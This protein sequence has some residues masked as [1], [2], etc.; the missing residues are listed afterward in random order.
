MRKAKRG[1][2]HLT[3]SFCKSRRASKN[4]SLVSG[5]FLGDSDQGVPS[6]LS[7]RLSYLTRSVASITLYNGDTIL[8]SCSGIV[9]ERQGRH[10]TRFL[11]SASLVRALNATNKDHDDL[12]IQVRLEGKEV[13]MG[14]MAEF[15]LDRNFAVVD[16][17][18]FLD[19]Q[20][21]SFQHAQI[22][23]HGETLVVI[24]RRVSGEI[25]TKNVELDG[26]SRVSEDDED[27]D[28]KISEAWEGGPLLSVDG[29]VVGMNLFLTTRRA[30][31]LP[32]GTILKHLEYY[33]TSQQKKTG[34]A[35]PKTSK[36]S[37]FGARPIGEKSNSHPEVHGDI[38]N[39]EQLD[40]DSMGYPKLPSSMLGAGMILVN[41]FEETF[42]DIHGEGVWRNFGE[43]AS[44][45]NRNVV[46]LASFNGKRRVFACTGFFIEWNGSTMIL[47]SASLVRNSGD[48]NK[49]V[50]N[51]RIE[52]LLNSQFREGTLQHYSL[53]YN[54]AL[55]S[56]KDYRA[57]RPSNTLLHWKKDFEVAAVGRCFE[58]GA[59]MATT[60]E[61]VSWTGTLDCDFLA[62]STCKIT[63]AGIGGP[64]VTL[65]GDV[66]GMNFY[67]KR[68]GTPFLLLV[69]IY[70]ILASFETKSELGEVGNDRHPPGAPFWKMDEDGKT[71][72]NRWPVLM[73][74]W[75]NP[76][77]VDEDK[78]DD[79]EFGFEPE[80]GRMPSYGYFKGRKLMLF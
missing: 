79:D 50:E 3:R 74:C 58:S 68:I 31:F 23:P 70:K 12:K 44:N 39:Q 56:V 52:V 46:A 35:R 60:G 34:L 17:H 29:M 1:G 36:A 78:S 7:D 57:L 62:T 11:T 69:D 59:L 8:F 47:T 53:H 42:G 73:P 6:G 32:W 28:C 37:R 33:W 40:L 26:D 10:L 24:G 72:L 64:L 18:A 49:I 65:D 19:V 67:D 61:L 76:D 30:V 77:Y 16:V 25:I 80:S 2:D 66:I 43:R 48:E 20:V 55:V 75:R 14:G 63:K 13:Y 4:E 38:L 41:T 22:L 45:I 27:L 21:G 51:L 15:D 54:V 5:R 9:M 71:K